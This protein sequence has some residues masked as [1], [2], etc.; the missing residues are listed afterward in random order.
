MRKIPSL[1]LGICCAFLFTGCAAFS[2]RIQTH[3]GHVAKVWMDQMLAVDVHEAWADDHA[4]FIKYSIF[5]S[6]SNNSRIFY[7]RAIWDSRFDAKV[8]LSKNLVVPVEYLNEEKWAEYTR[9]LKSIKVLGEKDWKEIRTK[10]AQS[11]ARPAEG[12]G[13]VIRNDEQELFLYYDASHELKVVELMDKPKDVLIDKVFTQEELSALIISTLENHLQFKVSAEKQILLDTSADDPLNPFLYVDMDKK[14]AVSLKLNGKSKKARHDNKLQQRLKSADHIFIDSHLVGFFIRPVSSTFKLLTSARD[15]TLE[16]FRP[17]GAINLLNTQPPAPLYDGEPMDLNEWEKKLDKV[18]GKKSRSKGTL[19]F[20][21]DGDEFFPRL[22][23]ALQNAQE[24]IDF[25]IFIF[26]ND[27]YGVKVADLLREK[28][29][30]DDVDVKVLLDGMGQIMGEGETPDSLPDDF[31]PPVSIVDY[32]KADS[33]IKVRVRFNTF[34]KADHIKTIIVDRRIC[35]TGGMNIGREYRY[36]WHDMMMEVNGPIVDDILREF[37]I[38]WTHA[39]PLGDLGYLKAL[40]VYPQA[41]RKGQGYPL[42]LLFTRTNDPQILKAQLAAIVTAKKYIYIN[43]A[44]FSD[45]VILNELIKARKRGV[46][47]RV[48][49]P[50]NG[51]HEI[52]NASNVVT[53]NRMFENGIR[54]FFYP[55]MSHIKAAV[56]DG[57]M[58]AGSANFDKLSFKDNLEFNVATSHPAVVTELQERLFAK[59]FAKS[60][61]M[62]EPLKSSL[63]D[64]LAE[65]LANQL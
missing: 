56:Y 9:G 43:N 5:F 21:I 62:T 50:V 25:R 7:A 16:A 35:F 37:K 54:V 52:M 3:P 27:D 18:V 4:V 12:K 41:N 13:A 59:D 57:W 10:L 38:A 23:E 15:T 17:D 19:K 8:D 2:K 51:N 40:F 33:E 39:S 53:A 63:K 55:G 14:V 65:F 46:D 1:V 11:I 47:V 22:I 31:T 32:L 60:K 58:C 42:R 64:H 48:I 34:L 49:L 44:Y 28:A 29:D 24:D 30:K 6:D 36:D 45:N 20:L 61:E 26:D